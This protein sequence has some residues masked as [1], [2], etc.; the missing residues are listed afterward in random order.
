MDLLR[1]VAERRRE[2]G[3]SIPNLNALPKPDNSLSRMTIIEKKPK[4]KVLKEYFEAFV[5]RKINEE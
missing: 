2:Q 3:V 1:R 5:E 4:A